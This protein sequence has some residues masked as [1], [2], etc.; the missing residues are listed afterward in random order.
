MLLG[1]IICW[2]PERRKRHVGVIEADTIKESAPARAGW[3]PKDAHPTRV[4]AG[5]VLGGEGTLGSP[6]A[7]VIRSPSDNEEATP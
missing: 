1:G 5:V 7:G 2:W 4:G 3:E 6:S